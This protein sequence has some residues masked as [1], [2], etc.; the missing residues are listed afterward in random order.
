MTHSM[1]TPRI[2]HTTG[3]RINIDTRFAGTLRKAATGGGWEYRP[4]RTESAPLPEPQHFPD[5]SRAL[6]HIRSMAAQE[7]TA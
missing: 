2:T 4:R 5:K 7:Q 3:G 6:Q 1:N